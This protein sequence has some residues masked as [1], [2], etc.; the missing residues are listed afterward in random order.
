MAQNV[1]F[2]PVRNPANPDRAFIYRV[3]PEV[4]TLGYDQRAI[5]RGIA[6]PRWNKSPDVV[7][8][9]LL[10]ATGNIV[11]LKFDDVVHV[12]GVVQNSKTVA[13]LS[14]FVEPVTPN[15]K[16]TTGAL[17]GLVFSKDDEEQ[18]WLAYQARE[19]G[20]KVV[21]MYSNVTAPEAQ[22]QKSTARNI[23]DGTALSMFYDT[24]R[25]WV[26]YQDDEGKLVCHNEKVQKTTSIDD[27]ESNFIS[28]TPIASCFIP[29]SDINPDKVPKFDTNAL[30]RV[31]VYWVRMMNRQPVLYRSHAD[32]LAKSQS[33]DFTTPVAATDEGVSVQKLAQIGIITD[34]K[35]NNNHLFVAK[36]GKDNISSVTDSWATRKE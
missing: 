32:L 27:D 18:A 25:W 13:L 2:A 29:R 14:P 4:C 34:K 12:Y 31:I 24:Q 28:G 36:E 3:A 22:D 33:A 5:N 23:K 17:A 1:N 11:T 21:I 8:S 10:A 26:I 30:G 35:N 20:D 19:K 9:T 6:A 7:A 15:F 16:A